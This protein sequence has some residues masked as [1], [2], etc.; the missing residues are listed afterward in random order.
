MKS[1]EKAERNV[2][3]PVVGV[4]AWVEENTACW[5]DVHFLSSP[6]CTVYKYMYSICVFSSERK[7]RAE[8]FVV[9]E[10]GE[11][12]TWMFQQPSQMWLMLSLPCAL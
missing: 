10:M 5:R 4:G 7:S 6:V 2:W 3:C 12:L 11:G 1:K 9:Q 8:I